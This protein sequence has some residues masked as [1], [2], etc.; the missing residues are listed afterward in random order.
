MDPLWYLNSKYVRWF[1][2]INYCNNN[3]IHSLFKLLLLNS[4][5][6]LKETKSHTFAAWEFYEFHWFL[7]ISRYSSLSLPTQA[8]ICTH[9]LYMWCENYALV[10]SP[11][12]TRWLT[13][14]IL[15]LIL[16]YTLSCFYLLYIKNENFRRKMFQR[17]YFGG[18]TFGQIFK[19]RRK[20]FLTNFFKRKNFRTGV[21]NN[22]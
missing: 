19:F 13:T 6:V 16:S 15:I 21:F 14:N 4:F 20:N 9:P 10:F 11:L 8:T 3:L 7:L 12:N 22:I 17:K 18:K 5:L 1:K 2:T